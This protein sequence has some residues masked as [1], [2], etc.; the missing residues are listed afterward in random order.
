VRLGV[1]G[2]HSELS[3]PLGL[4]LPGLLLPLDDL[5]A[6]LVVGHDVRGLGR[7]GTSHCEKE[8]GSVPGPDLGFGFILGAL[9]GPI[10]QSLI[11]IAKELVIVCPFL[12][13]LRKPAAVQP[14]DKEFLYLLEDH[15]S[16]LH[17]FL[18]VHLLIGTAVGEIQTRYCDAREVQDRLGD[19]IPG[20][21]HKIGLDLREIAGEQCGTRPGLSVAN[22]HSPGPDVSVLGL[23]GLV[24]VGAQFP[25]LLEELVDLGEPP[26][27]GLLVL[28][29][30]ILY[31]LQFGP[32]AG[33]DGL[34]CKELALPILG[35]SL[36]DLQLRGRLRELVAHLGSQALLGHAGIG[37]HVVE[38]LVRNGGLLQNGGQV[39]LSGALLLADGL[40]LG[41]LLILETSLE[42]ASEAPGVRQGT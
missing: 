8:Q 40:A 41:V 26:G 12:H 5:R 4:V 13:S 35:L 17:F 11:R 27:F 36:G 24:F 31:G 33:A 30:D 14:G 28:F 19:S 29:G 25:V 7:T 15:G 22:K 37:H 39:L 1:L 20:G 10:G 23:E 2:L 16:D 18:G 42:H 9:V 34:F 38:L 21:G 6:L 3:N 32:Q